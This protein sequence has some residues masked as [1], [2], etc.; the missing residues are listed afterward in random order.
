MGPFRIYPGTRDCVPET[1]F[2]KLQCVAITTNLSLSGR[3]RCSIVSPWA[4]Q[5][6]TQWTID[7]YRYW[8][9]A[10]IF[11][12]DAFGLLGPS[13][14]Y[15]LQGGVAMSIWIH[16]YTK[17]SSRGAPDKNPESSDTIQEPSRT[18]TMIANIVD[19]CQCVLNVRCLSH[20]T[21][22]LVY[23]DT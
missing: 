14:D 9:T 16:R 3:L 17:P 8:L 21:S 20:L 10:G 4:R 19:V 11:L 2:A 15:V 13:F 22:I 5:E 18:M 1:N 7:I 12:S 6:W 23:T